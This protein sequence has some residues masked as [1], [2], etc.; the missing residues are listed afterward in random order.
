[1]SIEDWRRKQAWLVTEADRVIAPSV[2]AALRLQRYFPG[3]SPVAAYHP[4]TPAP[5]LGPAPQRLPAGQPLR[6]AVLGAMAWHK[7]L[8][9][10]RACA[11]KARRER[12][13]LEFTVIGYVDPHIP[14]KQP[15]RSSGRYQ[16]GHLPGLLRTSESHLIW[17]PAQ[18]PETFSF[19][20]SACIRLGLP[21]VVPDLG[22]FVERV[23]GRPW[24][25]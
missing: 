25:W 19:T 11:E 2:D 12:L 6:I 16:N 13:P 7:G 5:L 1:V 17:F 3:L 9:N 20:L 4:G 15:Y 18:W 24:T 14:G 22:A 8:A 10:L 21:A 23:A